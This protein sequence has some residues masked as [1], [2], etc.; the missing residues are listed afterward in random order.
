M[1]V[2]GL[3]AFAL[4][5]LA[6]FIVLYWRREEPDAAEEPMEED[7]RISPLLRGINYLLSD[8]PDRALQEMVQVAR[9]RS[10]T[11]EVYMALGEMFRSKGEIGRAV[12]IHQNILARPDVAR[13]LHLQAH[14]ALGKDFQAGGLLDRSLKHYRKALEIRPDHP[15]ALEASLRIREQ[16]HEWIE[17]EALLSR[18]EQMRGGMQHLHRAYLF[19]QMAEDKL[20]AGDAHG[21][22]ESSGR[23]LALHQGCA[24]AHL[25]LIRLHLQT[26]AWD[27]VETQVRQML[28]QAP[29]HLAQV[30]PLLLQ[31][32]TGEA[33]RM[34]ALLLDCWHKT[35]D[36]E[37]ALTWLEEQGRLGDDNSLASVRE[38]LA[39]RPSGLR[40]ALRE[41]AVCPDGSGK[42]LVEQARTWRSKMK[43]F[44]CTECGVRVVDL[45]W[46]CPQC[47]AW[48]S[49]HAIREDGLT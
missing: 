10:E 14:L 41:I 21:A 12:R 11:A 6:L 37:L 44:V 34:H 31:S 20:L 5:G 40:A 8:E 30:V 19:A 24:Q 2:E 47:H 28:E 17:A 38:A 15:E 25:L 48:G 42:D 27:K 26:Q 45:R 29:E 23:A 9:L 13:E 22:R 33:D 3:L 46:Q 16:S 7:A 43:R 1:I 4:L 32:T 35:G 36:E 39:F 49:M 18:I